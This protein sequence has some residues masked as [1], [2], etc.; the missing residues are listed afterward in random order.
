MEK[1]GKLRKLNH[2][3]IQFLVLLLITSKISPT[4]QNLLQ[5]RNFNNS[6]Q[7]AI[8]TLL[9]D[10]N[11]YKRKSM[12]F[13]KKELEEDVLGATIMQYFDCY[14][15]LSP[16]SLTETYFKPTVSH[17]IGHCFGLDHTKNQ[18]DI[19]YFEAHDS[20]KYTDEDWETFRKQLNACF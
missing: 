19:M 8:E 3:K 12:T 20:Q 6:E 9:R 18:N 2:H 4:V 1:R 7:V 15:E 13:E 10:L 17:E 5:F 16:E 14:I 11:V